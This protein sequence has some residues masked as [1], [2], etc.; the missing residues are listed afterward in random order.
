[1]EKQALIDKAILSLRNHSL[2][3]R[4]TQAKED[5]NLIVYLLWQL[6]P[7]PISPLGL[8]V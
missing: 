4:M 8:V 1:M 3:V 2:T 5:I 7:S 6:P